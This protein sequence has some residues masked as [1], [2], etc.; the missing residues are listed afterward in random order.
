MTD[1]PPPSQ[2]QALSS[3]FPAPPPF[4][5]HFTSANLERL[6]AIRAASADP[7]KTPPPKDLPPELRYLVPPAPPESGT[8]QSFGDPYNID[9]KLPTLTEQGI[10]QLYPSP[11]ADADPAAT[12]EWSSTRTAALQ[13][14]A[15]SLL[16][17]F[18]ELVGVLSV[19][20]SQY[21]PKIDH[22]RTLFINFHHLLNEYRPHQ[23]RETLILMMEEQL[24]KCREE[25]RSVRALKEK[26]EAVLDGIADEVDG[27][28]GSKGEGVGG[29]GGGGKARGDTREMGRRKREARRVWEAL[30]REVGF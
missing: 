30:E 18:L 12:A 9:A 29:K 5:K 6:D 3:A 27:A 15:K 4:Y 10:E 14:I 25:T 1:Q 8:Y 22:L 13:K 26:V 20:P 16:F 19:D 17:N 23:A 2:P 28:V 11:P 24:A 21:A 7:E